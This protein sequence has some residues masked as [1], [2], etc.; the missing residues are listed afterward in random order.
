M[1]HKEL[2]KLLDEVQEQG[3]ETILKKQLV[4]LEKKETSMAKTLSTKYGEGSIDLET[5]TF[6]PS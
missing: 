2:F 3:E 1:K 5:G 6:T 4:D